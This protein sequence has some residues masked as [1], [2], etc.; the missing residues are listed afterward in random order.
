MVLFL[1]FYRGL[2]VCVFD[3]VF[4]MWLIWWIDG[5]IFVYIEVF[6][7]GV[8][9]GDGGSFCGCDDFKG[10]F[11]DVWFCWYD[12]Y[13]EEFWWEQVFFDDVG[14]YWE[15]NW[16]NWF[17]CIVVVFFLFLK[18]LDVLCDFDFLV[19]YWNVCYCCLCVWLVGSDVWDVFNGILYN[20]LVLGGFGNVGDNLMDVLGVL[21]CGMGICVWSVVEWYWLSWWLDGWELVWIGVFL[22]GG[23]EV[24]VGC[25]FGEDQYDGC[26]IQMWVIWLCIILCLVC[27][28]Q[29]VLIDGGC[30]WEINW[31]SDFEWQV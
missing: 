8:F 14:V 21:L 10:C 20:W 12:I 31:V 23:F 3:L 1:G 11:I 25:F 29:V 13:G 19:G 30:S 22:C 4:F 27:W 16:C 28:E 15:V 2:G 18:L 24:G 17:W 6:V 5:C 7:C 9:E 26:V